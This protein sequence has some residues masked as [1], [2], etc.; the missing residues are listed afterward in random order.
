MTNSVKNRERLASRPNLTK[1]GKSL[2]EKT[3]QLKNIAKTEGVN[4]F[5]EL[6]TEKQN[7]Y[8]NQLNKK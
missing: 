5:F 2:V 7:I 1:T 6:P 3:R 8:L 4:H